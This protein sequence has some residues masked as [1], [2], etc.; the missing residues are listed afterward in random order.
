MRIETCEDDVGDL[1][2]R[3]DIAIAQLEAMDKAVLPGR[4]QM[5][6]LLDSIYKRSSGMVDFKVDTSRF[7]SRPQTAVSQQSDSDDNDDTDD[8]NEDD[9]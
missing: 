5:G 8:D 9:D 4:E 2:E 6:K 1:I 7:I 3:I